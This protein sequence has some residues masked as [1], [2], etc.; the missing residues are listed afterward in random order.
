MIIGELID[1]LTA[2]AD[3]L[4]AGME[5]EVQIHLCRGSDRF[6]IITREVTIDDDGPG[7]LIQGH[8]HLDTEGTVRRPLTADLDS[9]LAKMVADP[10]AQPEPAPAYAMVSLGARTKYRIP[11]RAT[12]KILVPG[13]LEALRVGC[14]CDP[15]RNE[16]ARA[17]SAL[18]NNRVPL[19]IHDECP[20]HQTV[21]LNG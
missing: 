13:E 10:V 20:V 1:A 8:P 21:E 14:L 9:E 16:A 7:L 18:D 4:P 11:M 3:R 5:A 15:E 17:L 19:V 12:G 2:A 6:S